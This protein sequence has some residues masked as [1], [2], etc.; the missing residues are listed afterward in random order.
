MPVSYIILKMAE[1]LKDHNEDV[2][3]SKRQIGGAINELLEKNVFSKEEEELMMEDFSLEEEIRMFLED[4]ECFYEDEEGNIALYNRSFVNDIDFLIDSEREKYDDDLMDKIDDFFDYNIFI[5]ELLD[6]R[7]NKDLLISIEGLQIEIE[8]EYNRLAILKMDNKPITDEEMHKLKILTIKRNLLFSYIKGAY[9]HVGYEDVYS[10]SRHLTFF[11]VSSELDLKIKNEEL[12]NFIK[13]DPFHRA[14]FFL[15]NND[16]HNISN[17]FFPY[18]FMSTE[19]KSKNMF[20][21]EVLSV[22]DKRIKTSG[23]E[24]IE[25]DLTNAKFRLMCS[26][27]TTYGDFIMKD[28]QR[29]NEEFIPDYS[30]IKD[31]IY[32]FIDELLMYNDFEMANPNNTCFFE[33]TIKSILIEAYFNLTGDENVIMKIKSNSNYNREHFITYLLED[34]IDNYKGRIKRKGDE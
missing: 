13:E 29:D 26:I 10:Y 2:I 18:I 9:D 16:K 34:I 33:N 28:Y 8:K 6:I 4:S 11:D 27:D 32:Y 14:L 22:L 15:D 25:G 1:V 23:N 31:E 19:E 7:I 30:F 20:Y 12:Q 17:K 21:K 5:L 3:I 24:T